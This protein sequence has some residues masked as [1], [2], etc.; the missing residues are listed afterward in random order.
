MKRISF[1]GGLIVIVGCLLMVSCAKRVN[2]GRSGKEAYTRSEE[3]NELVNQ[4][5]K[6]GWKVHGSTRTLRGALQQHY[7]RLAANPDLME[8]I[9]TATNCTSVTVCRL[10]ALNSAGLD[11]AMAVADE[12]KGIFG[13]DLSV[14]ESGGEEYNRFYV[15]FAG[16]IEAQIHGQLEESFALIKMENG[17]NQYKIYFLM[18]RNA[19]KKARLSALEDAIRES[20]QGM[21]VTVKAKKYLE[22][23]TGEG[24]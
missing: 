16:K 9:G 7:G 8:R 6:E 20:E 24:R 22:E 4:W 13:R 14:N 15:S 2:E 5:T 3:L 10:A 18:D 23:S 12:V 19:A 11:Y 1:L 21:E 17:K